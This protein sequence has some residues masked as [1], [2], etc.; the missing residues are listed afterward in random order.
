MEF[1]R[2][3]ADR[4]EDENNGGLRW[5][6][7]PICT[8]LSEHGLP[9][10]PSTYYA[11][12]NR[13]ATSREHRDA[14]LATEVRRVHASNYGVYGGGPGCGPGG[15]LVSKL[16]ELQAPPEPADQLVREAS[17]RGS[18][19]AGSRAPRP[20]GSLRVSQWAEYNSHRG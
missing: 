18:A 11:D 9:I 6:V 16:T 13:P 14:L 1:I 8:V 12:V 19:G 3:H 5:G 2:E 17:G 4:R 7:E 15:R 20:S 10:A